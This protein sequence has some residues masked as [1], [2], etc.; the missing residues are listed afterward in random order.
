MQGAALDD[1]VDQSEASIALLR[2]NTFD[3]AIPG[4]LA[5]LAPPDRSKQ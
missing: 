1:S 2:R 5:A 4:K 3:T